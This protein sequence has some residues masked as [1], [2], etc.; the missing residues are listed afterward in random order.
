M[1]LAVYMSDLDD[2]LRLEQGLRNS[3]SFD[4]P[5]FIFA[6]LFGDDPGAPEYFGNLVAAE[7]LQN[8]LAAGHEITRL[9]YGQEFCEYLI[10]SCGDLEKAL[11]FARDSRMQFTYVTGFVTDAGLAATRR[12]LA[13]LAERAPGSEVVVNDWGVLAVLAEEFPTLPPVLGRLLIKQQRMAR[14]TTKAPP[15]NMRGVNAPEASV[16][17]RQ[18]AALRQLNLSIPDYRQRLHGLGVV[19]FDL[20]IVPQGVEVPPDAW[21]F[22]MSCYYPWGYVTGSRNCYTAGVL[23]PERNYVV[24]ESPCRAPCRNLNRASR[25]LHFPQPPVQRG[26]AVFIY[27]AHYAT[28]YWNGEIPVDRIVFEPW[29]PL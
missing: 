3:D 21:G 20:D 9:Y 2:L 11:S 25:V 6:S 14:F 7:W 17:S 29:I 27:H 8:Y 16:L 5:Q 1:E 12:N 23:D 19:R 26:N 15:V 4:I 24:T 18:V 28:P 10:P 22:G 13:W